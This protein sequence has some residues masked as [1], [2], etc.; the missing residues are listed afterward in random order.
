MNERR[1]EKGEEERRERAAPHTT[2]VRPTVEV[3]SLHVVPVTRMNS[4]LERTI[5]QSIH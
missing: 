4:S 5:L 1:N 3:A 2:H